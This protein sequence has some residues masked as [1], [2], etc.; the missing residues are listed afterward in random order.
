MKPAF[1]TVAC[2]EWTL[3]QVAERAQSLGFE[4]IELRTFGES[5]TEFACDPALTSSAKVRRVFGARGIEVLSLAT[6]LRFDEPVRPPVIG[7]AISDT[8]AS[9][10]AGKRAVDLALAIECPLVRVYG[11]DYPARERR[12]RALRR[13]ADRLSKVL[14][15]ADKS[16]VRL[17]LENG[18]AFA[19]AAE[20]MELVGLC[21]SPLLGVC[22]NLAVGSAAGEPVE[23]ALATLGDRLLSAR[24]KDLKA[25]RPCELGRGE[26]P[27]EQFVRAARAVGFDGPL[28]Y[29]WD[30]AWM[31]ELAAAEQVL[32]AAGATLWSWLGGSPALNRAAAQPQSGPSRSTLGAPPREPASSGHRR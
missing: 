1:S 4:A 14:D 24:I 7:Y 17:T 19:T 31:P 23:S 32:G 9:V 27:C 30:R 18:G 20:T 26:L 22:Y 2:P 11:F 21:D 6:G 28:V 29:E 16:G 3:E 25:G 5:S 15:H 10:R 13:I 12:S 8:E